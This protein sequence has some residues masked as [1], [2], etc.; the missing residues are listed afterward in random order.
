VG[1]VRR[2]MPDPEKQPP[3]ESATPK[4]DLMIRPAPP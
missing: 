2:N 4:K 1:E 3:A